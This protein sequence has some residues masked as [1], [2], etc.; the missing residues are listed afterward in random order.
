MV[1]PVSLRSLPELR[2]DRLERIRKLPR[3][4]QQWLSLHQGHHEPNAS[5]YLSNSMIPSRDRARFADR[6]AQF[7]HLTFV[8]TLLAN[9]LRH[10][11]GSR[12]TGAGFQGNESSYL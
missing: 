10:E 7:R 1:W 4:P 8:N 11:H 2:Q 6:Q 9:K 5:R 12:R 3:Y